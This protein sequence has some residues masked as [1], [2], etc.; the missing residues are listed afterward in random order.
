LGHVLPFQ[1]FARSYFG[2]TLAR[3]EFSK[4]PERSNTQKI[5]RYSTKG[6]LTGQKIEVS[7]KIFGLDFI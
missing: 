4:S 2:T 7:E 3:A 6:M 5:W 1:Q